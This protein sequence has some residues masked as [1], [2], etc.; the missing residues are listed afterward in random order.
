MHLTRQ[1]FQ[2]IAD[3]IALAPADTARPYWAYVFA[4]RLANTNP[5]FDRT[6]FL[7]ACKVLCSTCGQVVYDDQTEDHNPCVEEGR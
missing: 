3:T 1:H 5:A 2:F 7:E 4:E 6:R